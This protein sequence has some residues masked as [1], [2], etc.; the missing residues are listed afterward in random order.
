MEIV[1]DILLNKDNYDVIV[2]FSGDSDFLAIID[3][4]MQSGKKVH[5]YSSNNSVSHELRTG[6][7]S[8]TDIVDV[9]EIH[10]NALQQK[11]RPL[12]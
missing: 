2:L 9:P 5:I 7:S 4:L 3:Y 8:Y 1:M 6:A 10:G 11:K 12:S